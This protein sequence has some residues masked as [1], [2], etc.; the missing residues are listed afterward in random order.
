MEEKNKRPLGTTVIMVGSWDDEC[1]KVIGLGI[2]EGEE[3]PPEEVSTVL[4]NAR[5]KVAKINY[6]GT[7]IWGTQ[8]WWGDGSEYDVFR[9][10]RR[11]ENCPCPKPIPL[12]RK[13]A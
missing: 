5:I 6:G 4:H 12:A 7:L 2:Y 11:E 1:V 9:R 3:V 13:K 10:G 8:V